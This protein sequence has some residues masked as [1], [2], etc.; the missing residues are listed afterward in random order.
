MSG[1]LRQ[2]VYGR[3]Q[4]LDHSGEYRVVHLN[5][6]HAEVAQRNVG[7]D[8]DPN[9]AFIVTLLDESKDVSLRMSAANLLI[10]AALLA[11]EKSDASSVER[12]LRVL[13]TVAVEGGILEGSAEIIRE[14]TGTVRERAAGTVDIK[15][16]VVAKT[17]PDRDLAADNRLMERHRALAA[18]QQQNR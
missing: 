16:L 18:K 15:G 12:Y 6:A 11:A 17:T 7:Q 1:Q 10:Q 8:Q 13:K 4:P 9:S 2:R 3:G 14:L 5:A